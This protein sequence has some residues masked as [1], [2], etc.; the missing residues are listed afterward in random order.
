MKD[1]EP[2]VTAMHVAQGML[3]AYRSP[4]LRDLVADEV[5][6]AT[7]KIMSA[8]EA[9]QGRL[10]ALEKPI[11]T[12][13]IMPIMERLVSPGIYLH[14]SIRK[15]YI[16]DCV[17]QAIDAGTT[18]VVNVGAGYDTLAYRLS[19]RYDH[20]T[21]FEVDH[22]AT[23]AA[24]KNALFESEDQSPQLCL[25]PVDL[26]KKSLAEELRKSPA[27]DASKETIFIIE[28]VL[29]YLTE[30]QVIGTLNAIR[31]LTGPGTKLLATVFGKSTATNPFGK[32]IRKILNEHY[33]WLIEQE[34]IDSFLNENNYKLIEAYS[35]FEN[36]ERYLGN[37]KCMA[38]N[39]FTT[40]AECL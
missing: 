27:F 6:E 15:R 8:S 37:G 18:Q 19:K 23:Q 17:L 40:Y 35:D 26:T 25:L 4:L 24:K 13:C 14:Y 5:A 21:F 31:S 32:L 9:G 22:P 16:E 7:R 33:Y 29:L 2:S 34:D 38:L 11:A 30:E 36:K 1:N 28:G 12:K 20:V 3:I 10:A 39:A